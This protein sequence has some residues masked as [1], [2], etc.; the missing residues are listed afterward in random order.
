MRGYCPGCDLTSREK[1][2]L[3][4]IAAGQSTERMSREMNVTT[5]TLR[6]HVKN[7]LTKLGAHTRLEA[8][9]LAA[10]QNL[11]DDRIA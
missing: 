5:S 1:E 7:L 11:L 8:A 9:V 4:R 6:S 3:R 10:R 2:V